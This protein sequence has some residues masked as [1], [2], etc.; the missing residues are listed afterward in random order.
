MW[1]HPLFTQDPLT[2]VA[3]RKFCNEYNKIL[4]HN[5]F[6]IRL[7]FLQFASK[8]RF[9]NIHQQKQLIIPKQSTLIAGVVTHIEMLKILLQLNNVWRYTVIYGIGK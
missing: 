3:K 6:T 5:N 7:C 2:R 8:P 1:I 4:K 9:T